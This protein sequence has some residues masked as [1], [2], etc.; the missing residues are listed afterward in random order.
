M[1]GGEVRE[2][3]KGRITRAWHPVKTGFSSHELGWWE[4]F[5]QE[6]EVI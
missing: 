3:L 5:Q 2:S 1:P 6:S 4:G